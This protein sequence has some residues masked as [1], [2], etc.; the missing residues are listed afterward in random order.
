M[1]EHRVEG[2]EIKKLLKIARRQPLNFAFNP[3]KSDEDG[4]F[5]LHRKKPAPILAKEVRSEGEGNKFSFGTA[6]L[7][8]KLLKL[9]VERE[10][11]QL[12]KKMKRF[13]KA[14]KVLLNVQILDSDGNVLDADIEDDLPDDPDFDGEEDGARSDATAA[15]SIEPEADA[16][17]PYG[18]QDLVQRL[19]RAKAKLAELPDAARKK[20]ESA[21]GQVVTLIK[22]ADMEAAERGVAAIEAALAKLSGPSAPPPPPPPPGPDGQMQKLVQV[23]RTLKERADQIDDAGIRQSLLQEIAAAAALIKAGDVNSTATKL[24]QIRDAISGVAGSASKEAEPADGPA[25]EP[26]E[27]GAAGNGWQ[28]ARDAWLDA[29]LSLDSQLNAL[30]AAILAEQEHPE[31][32]DALKTVAEVGLNAL[33]G[34][35]RVKLMGAIQMLGR[36]DAVSMKKHGGKALAAIS[37]LRTFLDGNERVDACEGNPW[38]V[39]V[40]IR[41][42][43]YPPLD[44]MMGILQKSQATT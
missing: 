18:A 16:A 43:L 31:F 17:S 36:G 28:Q 13:L 12:A 9:Q 27:V 15:N 35:H 11:P 5:A 4:Y 44:Q 26:G 7:E 29:N 19:A 10:L 25:A 42:T 41:D 32:A 2:P 21:I 24:A 23:L 30:R 37:A 14:N 22:A 39:D 6:T 40:A 38:D 34:D 1:G 8:G 20:L 3:A 33:T